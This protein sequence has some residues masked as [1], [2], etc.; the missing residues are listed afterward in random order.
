MTTYFLDTNIVVYLGDTKHVFHKAITDQILCLSEDDTVAISLLVLYEL[1]Y[2]FVDATDDLVTKMEES[3]QFVKDQFPILP[4]TE[5]GAKI[6]AD[7]KGAY[8]MATGANKKA[9]ARHNIDFMLASSAIVEGA[10][11]VSN[12]TIFQTLAKIREDFKCENW[13]ALK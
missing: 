1:H 4:I 6:F 2:G 9:I 12:D 11:L 8:K 3:I 5:Q 7:L 13:T 10:V